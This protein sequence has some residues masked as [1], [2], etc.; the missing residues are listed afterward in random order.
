MISTINDGSNIYQ[1]LCQSEPKFCLFN[2]QNGKPESFECFEPSHFGSF[3]CKVFKSFGELLDEFYKD[4]LN[5]KI[6]SGAQQ[7]A[8]GEEGNGKT[9]LEKIL[10]Q[11]QMKVDELQKQIV[12]LN[13]TNY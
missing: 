12:I 10:D 8:K 7:K 3:D 6:Q 1:S 11:Q 9:K 13:A 4:E 5:T 2:N